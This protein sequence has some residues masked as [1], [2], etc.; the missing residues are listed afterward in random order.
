[1]KLFSKGKDGGPNSTVTGYW[2][3]EI[4]WLFSI[5]LLRFDHGSRDEYHNHAFNSINWVL[6]GQVEEQKFH[7]SRTRWFTPSFKPIVTLRRHFHRVVSLG[8]TWVLSFRGPWRQT[9]RE[10]DPK[11]GE[12]VTLT[13]GRKVV[14]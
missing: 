1:M 11:T 9:W 6:S 8:T 13:H 3:I 4:K 2:L 5:V 10:Y 12:Y 14:G 7:P